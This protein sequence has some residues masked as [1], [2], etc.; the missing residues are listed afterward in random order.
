[1]SNT[2]INSRCPLTNK[3]QSKIATEIAN[4][5]VALKYSAV[6]KDFGTLL[7]NSLT[8]DQLRQAWESV[9]A[10]FGPFEKILSQTPL[11]YQGYKVMKLRC[12]F[13]NDNASIEVTFND[14]NKV[15]GLFIKP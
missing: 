6:Q 13:A 1:L 10:Q 12:K 11:T 8:T 14:E 4:N 2:L 7:K 9:I 15:I 3:V 5:L